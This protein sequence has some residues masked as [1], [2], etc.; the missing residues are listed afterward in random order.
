MLNLVIYVITTGFLATNVSEFE[1]LVLEW[2]SFWIL[3][4]DNIPALAFV[5][6]VFSGAKID[7]VTK[8]SYSIL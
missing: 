5:G 3:F 2:P 1:P 7:Q 6:T 8:K 4:S